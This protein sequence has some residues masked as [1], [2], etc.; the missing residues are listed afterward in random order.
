MTIDVSQ[1]DEFSGDVARAI[2]AV[3]PDWTNCARV[4]IADDGQTPDLVVEVLAPCSD[5]GGPKLVVYTEDQEVTVVFDFY[6]MHF[7]WPPNDDD[8]SVNPMSFIAAILSENVA[9]ASGW[10]GVEWRGSWLIERDEEVELPK[11]MSSIKVIRVRSWS[12]S[13]NQ[14]S[15]IA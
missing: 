9:V 8:A 4:D 11:N 12:G 10:D 1:L 2:F 13:R 3:Y 15:E 7:G 5:E 6:H 14:D